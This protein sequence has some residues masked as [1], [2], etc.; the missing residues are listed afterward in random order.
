M[1]PAFIPCVLHGSSRGSVLWL[2][3]EMRVVLRPA[4]AL[5]KY[6]NTMHPP[7]LQGFTLDGLALWEDGHTVRPQPLRR[8]A[9][10]QD[11]YAPVGR[12][13]P[14]HSYEHGGLTHTGA[15]DRRRGTYETDCGLV[16]PMHAHLDPLQEMPVSCQGC[17]TELDEWV[18]VTALAGAVVEARPEKSRPSRPRATVYEH[19][20]GEVDYRKKTV[21]HP[22]EEPVLE[23]LVRDQ[24]D[25]KVDRLSARG[26]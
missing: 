14:F 1:K 26:A 19:M 11:V 8:A 13:M 24:R 12:E 15:R 5:N 22:V 20:E 9:P 2:P 3:G 10:G 21:R 6:G 16:I 23:D 17:R 4:S 18:L 25:R 7:K